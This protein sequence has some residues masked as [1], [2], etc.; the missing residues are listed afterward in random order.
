MT[1][2]GYGSGRLLLTGGRDGCAA[3]GGRT[4]ATSAFDQFEQ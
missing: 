1:G 2:T 4:E 3:K